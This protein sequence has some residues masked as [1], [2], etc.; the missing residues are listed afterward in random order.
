MIL[1]LWLYYDIIVCCL[2][3]YYYYE[4]IMILSCFLILRVCYDIIMC[5]LLCYYYYVF[6][7]I[8]LCF[9]LGYYYYEFIW[10]RT[11]LEPI[12][13]NLPRPDH[14]H[15]FGNYKFEY[16]QSLPDGTLEYRGSLKGQMS[17]LVNTHK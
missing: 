14:D 5:C 9:L 16:H 6:I 11:N 7:M 2:L 12:H 17:G 10:L 1:C 3:W 8:L 4:F 15:G 13:V